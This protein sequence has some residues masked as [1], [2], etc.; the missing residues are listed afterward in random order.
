MSRGEIAYL[1][2]VLAA[3]I[4]YLGLLAYGVATS[5]ERP[6]DEAAEQKMPQRRAPAG[7]QH[8]ELAG[9]AHR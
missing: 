5:S 8:R 6:S 4:S 9:Q 3:F 7:R 1:A 2:L